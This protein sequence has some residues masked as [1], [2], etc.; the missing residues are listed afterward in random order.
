[1]RDLLQEFLDGKELCKNLNP[2]SPSVPIRHLVVSAYILDWAS[3][4]R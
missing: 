2:K 3:C 4:E 1:V